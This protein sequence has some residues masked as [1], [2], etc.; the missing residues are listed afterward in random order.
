MMKNDGNIIPSVK[1]YDS[2]VL[3][4]ED[5]GKIFEMAICLAYGIPYD[6]KYKYGMEIPEKLKLRLCKLTEMFPMCMH[7]ARK[8]SRY[9]YTCVDDNSKHLSAKSTKKGGGKVAPQVIGQSQP[10]KFCDLLGIEYTTILAKR[11][12]SKRNN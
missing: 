12:Y 7:T 1:E 3:Q 11:I 4:T 5:T 8:G 2:M 9:D 6:G 10:K